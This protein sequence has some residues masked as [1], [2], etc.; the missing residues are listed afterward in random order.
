MVKNSVEY[1]NYRFENNWIEKKGIQQST[2]FAELIIKNINQRVLHETFSFLDWACALGQLCERWKYY[3][4]TTDIAGYDFSESA[5]KMASEINKDI[6]FTNDVPK[7]KF[8]VVLSSNFLEHT[9]MWR[10][11]LN[12]MLNMSNKFVAVLV[13]Y[14]SPIGDEHCV[15]FNEDMFDDELNEFICIQKKVIECENKEMWNGNQLLVTYMKKR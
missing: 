13:P 11:Y 2:Y 6:L 8:D 3:T 10:S 15:E 9:L 1:W 4:G 12:R 14:M 5:C 7:R